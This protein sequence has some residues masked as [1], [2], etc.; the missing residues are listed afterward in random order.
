MKIQEG[1]TFMSEKNTAVSGENRFLLLQRLVA[2]LVL[3][4]AFGLAMQWARLP[5]PVSIAVTFNGLFRE[6]LDYSV[7]LLVLG[8]VTSGIAGLGHGAGKALGATLLL[9]AVCSPLPDSSPS[10]SVTRRCRI[11]CRAARKSSTSAPKAAR[12]FRRSS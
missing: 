3:G 10:E 11:F 2:G 5:L 8:Y 12:P 1:E 9:S 6:F 7:P 4:T